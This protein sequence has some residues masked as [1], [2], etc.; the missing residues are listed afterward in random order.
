MMDAH[1]MKLQTFES[2]QQWN[3]IIFIYIYIY[4]VHFLFPTVFFRLGFVIFPGWLWTKTIAIG[5]SGLLSPSVL[6]IILSAF[7]ST[8][9]AL[10]WTLDSA[11][12]VIPCMLPCFG[13]L[14][15]LNHVV[16]MEHVVTYLLLTNHA[17]L[18]GEGPCASFQ[19]WL[20]LAMYL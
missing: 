11:L 16:I 6:M 17:S 10:S 1:H 13:D 18:C 9:P 7:W 19:V 20:A 4:T 12:F 14:D 8:S 2:L 3:C 5:K 15:L